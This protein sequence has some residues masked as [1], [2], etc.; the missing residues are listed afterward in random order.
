MQDYV[1]ELGMAEA[2]RDALVEDAVVWASQHGLVG[3]FSIVGRS[4]AY[5]GM[6]DLP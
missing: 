5:A 1:S 2:T 4:P 6:S 3:H